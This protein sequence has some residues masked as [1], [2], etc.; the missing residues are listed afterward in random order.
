MYIRT[1]KYIYILGGIYY[2]DEKQGFGLYY[3]TVLFM[4]GS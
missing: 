4:L 1:Y 3:F 2:K